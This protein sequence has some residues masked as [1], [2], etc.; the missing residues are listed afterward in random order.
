M[1]Y[2]TVLSTIIMKIFSF[3]PEMLV[4]M[5]MTEK[6]FVILDSTVAIRPS[7]WNVHI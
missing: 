5:R 2:Y 7:Y 1:M 6:L 4:L 3:F